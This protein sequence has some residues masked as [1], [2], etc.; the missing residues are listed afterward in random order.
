M[1][2]WHGCGTILNKVDL[3]KSLYYYGMVVQGHYLEFVWEVNG[4]EMM[5]QHGHLRRLQLQHHL[6]NHSK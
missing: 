4:K 2:C 1:P 5:S 3:L 6:L